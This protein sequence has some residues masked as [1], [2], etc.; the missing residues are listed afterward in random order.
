MAGEAGPAWPRSERRRGGW[1]G[2]KESGRISDDRRLWG[3]RADS[4]DALTLLRLCV[5]ASL[6]AT[7][8][9]VKERKKAR[10]SEKRRDG[11]VK[12]KR[13]Y[14]HSRHLLERR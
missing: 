2:E 1:R 3:C 14:R 8:L 9:R 4:Y 6:S 5:T 13:Q 10:G 11:W 7:R 12:D